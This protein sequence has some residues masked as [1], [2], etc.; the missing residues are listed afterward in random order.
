MTMQT[1]TL[2]GV[3]LSAGAV[4]N[5]YPMPRR[6]MLAPGTGDFADRIEGRARRLERRNVR[7]AKRSFLYS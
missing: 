6:V 2:K 4:L 1:I 3:S 5:G 7:S